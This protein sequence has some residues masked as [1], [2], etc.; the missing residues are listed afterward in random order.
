MQIATKAMTKEA[1]KERWMNVVD[2]VATAACQSTRSPSEI[3]I[4]GVTKYVD[5]VQTRWLYEAGCRDFGE[6]R[7]Q[8]LWDKAASLSDLSIR[9]HLIGHLQRNKSRRT[10]PLIH[11]I[12][13]VDSLRLAQ[14]LE[15]DASEL[16]QTIEVLLEVNVSGDPNKT[17][18]IP[19]EILRI[20]PAIVSLSNLQVTG[21]MGMSGLG[22]Q[23]PR[24]DFAVIRSLRDQLQ[25]QLGSSACLDKLSM[26]MSGDYET[27]IQEGSTI[28][29]I[30]S[31][32]FS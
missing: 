12:H 7:P 25:I 2:R 19:M 30:G 24:A 11:C 10:L 20:A 3:T 29:R 13:S 8:S 23:E 26:G 32:L 28:V 6:S 14:Q 31:S 5:S 15:F 9:W 1:I 16:G 22:N 27:A 4:V 18:M 21:L 17:G